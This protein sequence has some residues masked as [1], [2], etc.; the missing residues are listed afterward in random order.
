MGQIILPTP[1]STNASPS[2]T[3]D[4]IQKLL[5]YNAAQL[6]NTS[7]N[8]AAR[9]HQLFNDALSSSFSGPGLLDSMDCFQD[10]LTGRIDYDLYAIGLGILMIAASL[11]LLI[12]PSCPAIFFTGQFVCCWALMI[13]G[14]HPL[15]CSIAESSLCDRRQLI[16]GPVLLA[17]LLSGSILIALGIM[18]IGSSRFSAEVVS[19]CRAF[20]EVL[21]IYI[22]CD[23]L[24]AE[25]PLLY[26][27]KQCSG[28]VG[29]VIY[30]PLGSKE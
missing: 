15:V 10:E 22:R 6:A 13:A 3:N 18:R 16:A 23:F 11:L 19:L 9:C 14:C 24:L 2:P 21:S 7:R 28:S 5:H 25:R 30:W 1:L 26:C 12:D 17:I 27:G 4:D 29:S 20:R 8:S